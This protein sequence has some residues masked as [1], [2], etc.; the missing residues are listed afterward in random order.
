MNVPVQCYVYQGSIFLEGQGTFFTPLLNK[1]PWLYRYIGWFNE[2]PV[3]FIS[4]GV[5]L[6]NLSE[7]P[8]LYKWLAGH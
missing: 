7:G 3:P 2:S 1:K 5:Y 6:N 8:S 4:P